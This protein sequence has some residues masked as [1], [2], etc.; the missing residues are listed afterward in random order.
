MSKWDDAY[1]SITLDETTTRDD[2]EALWAVFAD[3]G[4]SLPGVADFEAGIDSLIPAGLRRKTAFLTHPVFNTH[5]SETEMLRYIRSLSD[6][7]LA[8]DRTMIPLGSCTM[9][10]NATA[11]MIPITWPELANLHPFAPRDQQAGTWAI[12]D[13][14][15]AWLAQCTGYAGVSLQPNAG[16]QGEYA[17]LLAISAFHASRGESQRKVCLIPESAHG[18][19]PASRADGRHAGRRGEVRRRRQCRPRRPGGQ[20]REAQRRTRLRDDHLSQHV[21]RVRS[22]RARAVR[23]GAPARRARVRRRRQHERAGR[24]CG[25]G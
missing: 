12:N 19:N 11:E 23:A 14:L 2:I 8:L 10:L 17:G 9:K 16:S 13:Q 22:P 25:A 5:H 1:L 18:T 7:D 15:C 4:Q 6:K 3:E 24:R 21:R 20:M